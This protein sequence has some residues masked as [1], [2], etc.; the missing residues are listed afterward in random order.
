MIIHKGARPIL[1]S[2]VYADVFEIDGKAYKVFKKGY[3]HPWRTRVNVFQ[4][5]CEAYKIAASDSYLKDHIAAFFGPCTL[6]DVID[7]AGASVKD[8][9][10]LDCCY[11][12]EVVRGNEAKVTSPEASMY[13]HIQ[14]AIKRF[15]EL[16]VKVS[17]SSVF[18]PA[19]S[20]RFKFIDIEKKGHFS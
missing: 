9:Y 17:D 5:Q 18:E 16:G 4:Y 7:E 11:M 8:Q 6:E 14:R 12:V 10:I 19:D 13:K 1:G 20:E 15:D 3:E 2:G